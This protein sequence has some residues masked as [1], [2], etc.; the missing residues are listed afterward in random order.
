MTILKSNQEMERLIEHGKSLRRFLTYNK[1]FFEKD[2]KYNVVELIDY[3]MN[4]MDDVIERNAINSSLMIKINNTNGTYEYKLL[5][6]CKNNVLSELS[7]IF[8]NMI[9]Y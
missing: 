6:L 4:K 2:M 5:N 3:I 8:K 7:G 9:T 1:Y